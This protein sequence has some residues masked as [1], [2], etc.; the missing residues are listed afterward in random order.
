VRSLAA[1]VVLAVCVACREPPRATHVVDHGGRHP[2]AQSPAKPTQ[3]DALLAH[4]TGRVRLVGADVPARAQAGER[5]RITL[6]FLVEHE[7]TSAPRVFVHASAPGAE[8]HQ[9]TAD[10]APAGGTVPPSQWRSGDLVI[11]AFD[12]AIPASIGVDE[13]VVRAGLFGGKER[14][15]VTPRSAHDGDHRVTVGRIHI[16]GAPLLAVRADVPKRHAPIVLDGVLDDPDW[17]RAVVLAPFHAHDGRSAITRATSARML[18]DDE[19]LWVAF[20]VEDPDVFTVYSQRDDPLYDS[21][22]TEIFIDADGD[23]DVYVELQSAADDVHFDAAFAGGRRRNMDRAW[24]AAF[25]T[26]TMRTPRGVTAEWRVPVASLRDVP[27]GEPR[28][29]AS[30]KVNLFR[31]ERLRSST[32]RVTGTEASA[33]SSPLSGDFHNLARFGTVTFVP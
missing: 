10:H 23:G 11:D 30:W 15:A 17:Q 7:L 3:L 1:L 4:A 8:L 27:A 19:A 32:Q 31:L 26:K 29:G 24:D 12:L 25:D 33:W 13:L 20:D 22:A 16:D 5:A 14:W 9:A 18:W 21:E 6:T 2:L 28:A